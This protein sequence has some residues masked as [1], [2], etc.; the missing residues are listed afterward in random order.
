MMTP[1]LPWATQ[2]NF[3]LLPDKWYHCNSKSGRTCAN[4]FFTLFYFTYFSL[5]WDRYTSPHSSY[6]YLP[7]KQT[8]RQT[9]KQ[10]KK[11]TNSCHHLKQVSFFFKYFL[12]YVFYMQHHLLSYG[13]HLNA[14]HSKQICRCSCGCFSIQWRF[15]MSSVCLKFC[16][17]QHVQIYKQKKVTFYCMKYALEIVLS[18][19][20]LIME[21][22][23]VRM[24]FI[25]S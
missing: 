3:W 9:N 23:W 5:E 7:E 19:L 25:I 14:T 18:F 20:T 15:T 4:W 2:S 1:P 6:K 22:A 21:F 10:T 12:M 17:S 11:N 16:S 13:Y 8:K 24:F